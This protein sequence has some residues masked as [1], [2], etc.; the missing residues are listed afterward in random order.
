M[1]S[2]AVPMGCRA[3]PACGHGQ[4]VMAV[5][6]AL[7]QAHRLAAVAHPLA[8]LIAAEVAMLALDLN[9]R[10]SLAGI[11]CLVQPDPRV[12]TRKRRNC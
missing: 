1:A 8:G 9:L 6:T 11:C 5:A 2:A 7:I 12:S 10:E 3:A 4:G